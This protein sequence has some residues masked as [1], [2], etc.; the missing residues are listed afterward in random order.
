MRTGLVSITFRKLAAGEVAGLAAAAGLECIEWGGD[1]HVPHG[2]VAAARE[3]RA[4]TLDHGLAI[5]A[6]GSYLRLGGDN[7]A[8]AEAVLDT[9]RELGAPTVRVWAG[10]MGS[11]ACDAASRQRIVEAACALTAKAKESGLTISY[12][13]HTGT[14]TDEAASAARLLE[15]TP[16]TFSFWQPP[17]GESPETCL[18]SLETVLPRLSNVHVFHWWPTGSHRLPLEEGRDRWLLYLRRIRSAGRTPDVLLEFV[19]DDAPAVLNREAATLRSIL[20]DCEL[21]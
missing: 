2:D 5:S 18:A 11:A 1:I 4:I 21:R 19:P 3:V 13:Y 10:T 6:Y 8:A 20:A 7:Q 12:E 15:E 9:A 17:N 16:D 14:L